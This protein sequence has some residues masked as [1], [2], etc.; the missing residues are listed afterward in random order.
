MQTK[1]LEFS[2]EFAVLCN[3]RDLDVQTADYNNLRVS[4]Q[5]NIST[6]NLDVGV[7]VNKN[8]DTGN[9]KK[10]LTSTEFTHKSGSGKIS[11]TKIQ[12]Y[13]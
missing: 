1:K 7:Y 9:R 2:K 11:L 3:V 13:L 5:E 10:H 6:S 4:K 12:N 8:F